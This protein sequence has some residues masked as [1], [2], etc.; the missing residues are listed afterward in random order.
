MKSLRKTIAVL[1]IVL[2]VTMTLGGPYPAMAQE[3]NQGVSQNARGSA[4]AS[5]SPGLRIRAALGGPQITQ[6]REEAETPTRLQ[7]IYINIIN[8]V[9]VGFNQLIPFLPE[10]FPEAGGPA[11]IDDLV[12][13]EI[14]NDGTN[15]FVEIFSPGAVRI[16][17]DN[18]AFCIAEQCTEPGELVGRVMEQNDVIVMQLGGQ[19]D[20]A[21]ANGVVT[22]QISPTIG[23]LALHDFTG[24]TGRDPTDQVAMVDYL[25]WGDI[26]QSFGLEDT[27]SAAGLWIIGTSI[28]SS[29]VNNSFQLDRDR[30]ST[31]GRADDY[32]VVPFSQQTLGTLTPS[33]LEPDSGAGQAAAASP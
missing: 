12:I 1:G 32:I 30:A 29:L 18:W 31:G 22:L 6:S 19:F 10:L 16:E 26:F 33:D 15:T 9:F 21:L 3:T 8:A 28:E 7:G 4:V 11:G 5:R 24:A 27:A 14:A 20:G 2:I 23:E 13:T 17:L 25:Q